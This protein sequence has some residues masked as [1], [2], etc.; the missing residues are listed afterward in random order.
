MVLRKSNGLRPVHAQHG[1]ARE[2][3][4]GR[5]AAGIGR[6]SILHAVGSGMR[7]PATTRAGL[8]LLQPAAKSMLS[9]I[10]GPLG[11]CDSKRR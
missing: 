5:R 11:S 1:N 4:H 10:V 6:L 3:E 9:R 7:S 8:A 2:R